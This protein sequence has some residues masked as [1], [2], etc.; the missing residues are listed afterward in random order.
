MTRS[1]LVIQKFKQL[2]VIGCGGGEG[3]GEVDETNR[4]R[5]WKKG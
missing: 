4:E 1:D 5:K 3:W 2:Q